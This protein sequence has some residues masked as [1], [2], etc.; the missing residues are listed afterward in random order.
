MELPSF[1]ELQCC[2]LGVLVAISPNM[3][4]IHLQ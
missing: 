3:E 1:P 2:Q 4:N